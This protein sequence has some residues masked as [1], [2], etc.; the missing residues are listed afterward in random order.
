MNIKVSTAR[1]SLAIEDLMPGSL[2]IY[3]DKIAVKCSSSA[4]FAWTCIE[5]G[6]GDELYD[7]STSPDEFNETLVKQITLEV[8]K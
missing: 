2:F 7:Y 6:T 8:I 5:I 4:G 1:E 3:G